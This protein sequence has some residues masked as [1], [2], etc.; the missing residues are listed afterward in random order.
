MRNF[1]AINPRSQ[2]EPEAHIF[3]RPAP[4]RKR[5]R[6]L[7]Y[8]LLFMLIVIAAGWFGASHLITQANKIFTNKESVFVRVGR[9]ILGDDK[10]LAGEEEGAVNIL[11]LGIGGEGHD[12]GNLTD[13]MMVASIDPKNHEVVLI[14]IPRDFAITLP[15]RGL[16]KIN[17]AYAYAEKDQPGNGGTAAIAAAEKVTGLT[18]PYFALVDFKGF[19]QAIDHVGGVDVVIDNTF[20]DS[21]YPDEKNGYLPPVTFTKGAEHMNGQRALIFARSRHSAQNNE[22]S[23]FARSERQKKIIAALKDKVMKL[24]LTDL[25]TINNVLSDFTDHVRTNL[26]PYEIKRIAD[27]TQGISSNDIYSLS[28]APQ[29]DLICSDM[30]EITP[31]TDTTPAVNM[32]VVEPCKGKSLSDI[33]QYLTDIPL[34]AKLKKENATIEVQNSNASQAALAKWRKLASSGFD[35]KI[36]P[37]KGKV[38]YDRTIFY[39]NSKGG[40]P[41]TLEY[42]K[43]NFS[44]TPSDVPYHDS[45]ADFVIILGKDALQ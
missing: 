15:G 37:F 3:N 20:T 23:D 25:R 14:S 8:F 7:K 1:D 17:A 29:G 21:T 22:G 38:A 19:V 9:L 32:Y 30:L 44:F 11:L 13:T 10:P 18:I 12:G 42:L 5:H 6:K 34:L 28:L 41:K 33:H 35:V 27:M 4:A 31:A 26:E 24:G 40:K 36:V 45:G 39:D 2:Q 43:N 16:Q